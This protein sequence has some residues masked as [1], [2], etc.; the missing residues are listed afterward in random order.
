VP[1]NAQRYFEQAIELS[2]E[3]SMRA[4]LH[5]RAGQMAWMGGHAA[6]ARSHFEEAIAAFDSI[7]L[8]HP[9]ARVSAALAEIMWQ[10]GEIED[11]IQR[12]TAAFEVMSAEERDADLATHAAQLGRLL[13]FSGR[14]EEALTHIE[15]ALAVA[16]A[17]KAPEPFSQALNTKGLIL[18]THGRFDEGAL[19]VRHALQ[20]ALDND[21]ASAALR[22]YSNVA[23]IHSWQDRL[24]DLLEW[25]R[26]G[27]AYARKVGN[28]YW[29][30]SFVIGLIPDLIYL[31]RWDEALAAPEASHG[32]ELP[33]FILTTMVSLIPLYVARDQLDDARRALGRVP[34]GE[35][36][37]DVQTRAVVQAARAPLL[38]A[39]GKLAE[40]LVAGEDAWSLR[41]EIGVQH[42]S[43][44][45]GLVEAIEAALGL[46][47]LDR[48]EQLID[49]IGALRPGDLTPYLQAQGARLSARLSAARGETGNVEDGFR[50]AVQ[51]FREISF[52]PYLGM[53]LVEQAE[54][55]TANG[56]HE[57]AKP[58]LDEAR[59][60]F[61]RLEAR[62]WLERVARAAS[63]ERASAIRS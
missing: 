8:T 33:A 45:E 1:E 42:Q 30:L 10:E 40:A 24:E 4:E 55:L 12:L 9:S 63:P 22:A 37:Q 36:S 14:T 56:R 51:R 25:S 47:D 44:K 39:E 54:W 57:D 46:G 7:G 49:S 6:P 20:V 18:A 59:E 32:D 21:L 52:I 15:V 19:L 29:D 61:E 62:P 38:R 16:E 2:T 41:H 3:A 60:I 5:E 50:S 34:D 13:Y 43:V 31:G 11:A 23:A 48:A 27:L 28:R 26:K 35:S 53:T 58:L 17:V